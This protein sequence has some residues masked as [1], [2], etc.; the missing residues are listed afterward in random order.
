MDDEELYYHLHNICVEMKY[1]W[2]NM[3]NDIKEAIT[4][5]REISQ[6]HKKS[7][8]L[9]VSI[10][11]SITSSSHNIAREI[12]GQEGNGSESKRLWK[13]NSTMHNVS[14][15]RTTPSWR[16]EVLGNEKTK[17]TRNSNILSDRI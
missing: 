17:P 2:P 3:S 7:K 11:S 5:D 9:H 1:V 13:P 16:E 12:Q 14:F 8:V 6:L 4:K 15:V 10:P